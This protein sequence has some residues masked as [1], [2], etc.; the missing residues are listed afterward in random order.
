MIAN[1]ISE[2]LTLDQFLELPETKPYSEYIEGTIYQK[3]MPK[4]KHSRIQTR[5]SA[6]INQV[7]ETTKLASAFTELRCTL[8][9][10]SLVPDIAVF[11]WDRIPLDEAGEV[12]NRIM[13]YPDWVI[14]IL[15]P[16]QTDALVIDKILFFLNQGTQLG[17]L[18]DPKGKLVITFQPK[19]QPEVKQEKDI[20]TV[21][22][23]LS[24]WQLS[25][26]ELFQWLKYN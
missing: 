25:A 9:G 12:E 16:E 21:L 10:R 18:I 26:N 11:Q 24:H 3:T 15:S 17:W 20:L 19:Q 5:L 7:G 23:I 2:T 22:P 14:E 8:E 4:G 6:T 13:T 1:P